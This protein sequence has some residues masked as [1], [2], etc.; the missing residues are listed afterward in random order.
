MISIARSSLALSEW[1]GFTVIVGTVIVFISVIVML[2]AFLQWGWHD[3]QK[4]SQ[5]PALV[6]LLLLLAF[7]LGLLFWLRFRPRVSSSNDG[8]AG[9]FDLQKF[10]IQ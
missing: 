2:R 9:A 5:N 6:L 1:E 7:P 10:R 8:T 3:A 4:R